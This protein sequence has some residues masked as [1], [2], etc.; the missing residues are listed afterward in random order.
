MGGYGA[1]M[2]TAKHPELFSAVVEYGGALAKWQDLVTFNSA[3]ATGMYNNVEA[4]FLPYSLWD[5]TDQNATAIR[6]TVDYKMIVGDADPQENS[7]ERFRD[8]LLAL[9]I[10]PHYQVLPGVVHLGDVYY[11]EGSGLNFLDNHFAQVPEPMAGSALLTLICA[12]A[13]RRRR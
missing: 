8:H 6:T 4:N 7:N 2:Y 5:L 11:Q 13:L 9:N 1:A 3:T 10:D 12:R